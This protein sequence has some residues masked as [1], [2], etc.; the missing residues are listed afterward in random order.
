MLKNE[1]KELI[2]NGNVRCCDCEGFHGATGTCD[3]GA[4][5]LAE[6]GYPLVAYG[7]VRLPRRCRASSPPRVQER[8]LVESSPTRQVGREGGMTSASL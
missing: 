5:A 4:E 1:V 8:M 3:A 6:L 7:G 2:D